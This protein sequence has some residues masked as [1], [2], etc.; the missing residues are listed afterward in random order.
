LDVGFTDTWQWGPPVSSFLSTLSSLSVPAPAT[1]ASV[2]ASPRR[3]PPLPWRRPPLPPPL[4]RRRPPLP[5]PPASCPFPHR[6]RWHAGHSGG[7]QRPWPRGAAAA[8][9]HGQRG[10][11]G[12]RAGERTSA[13]S[14]MTHGPAASRGDAAMCRREGVM[15]RRNKRVGEHKWGMGNSPRRSIGVRSAETGC[16]R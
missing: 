1:P 8:R 4:P 11:H 3:R 14:P 15:R 13:P 16:P 10:T 7:R 2:L 12:T 5:L 9:R 6:R